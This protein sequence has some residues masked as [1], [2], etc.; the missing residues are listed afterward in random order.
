MPTRILPHLDDVGCSAGSVTAWQALRAAG[1]VRSA[2]VMVPCP[3]YPAAVEDWRSDPGQDL[4]IHITLNAEWDLYRWRPLTGRVK[5][6]VD[7]EGFFHRRPE[8]VVA[9]ADASAVED[10]M[11]AQ[12]EQ[13]LADGIALTHI[14][15][16]MGTAYLPPFI[17][18]LWDLSSRYGLPLMVCRDVSVLFDIVRL[19]Q[20][21]VGYFRELI[22]EAVE[23]GN[24]VFDRFLIGFT[25]E[26]QS[27]EEFISAMVGQAGDGL[28]WLALH[29]NAPGDLGTFAPHMVWPRE[30][31][32][33]L[34]RTPQSRDVFAR[35]GAETLNWRDLSST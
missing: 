9:Q 19:P 12:I 25:P 3:W 33:E 14:D 24:P 11:A 34:F 32:Y 29:A 13:A 8:A 2:S 18:R 31:E 10:E 7:D 15:A 21:D 6:L 26:G 30:A 1:V 20:A 28:H 4:G 23:R 27:A 35:W 16:H 22:A 5:G 17:E